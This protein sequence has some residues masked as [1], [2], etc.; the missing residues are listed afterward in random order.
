MD[1]TLINS[2]QGIVNAYRYAFSSLNKSF[3]EHKFSDAV[4]GAPLVSVFSDVFSLSAEDTARAVKYYRGYYAEKGKFEAEVY[5]EITN[6]L[7]SLKQSGIT[8]AVATLKNEGFARE[9]LEHFNISGYFDS[10]CGMDN[11]DTLTKSQLI[12]K[13]VS[14]CSAS[15][16]STV[17][18]GD[19]EY[20]RIGADKANVNFIAVTYG[21][22]FKNI[23]QNDVRFKVCSSPLCVANTILSEKKKV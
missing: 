18:V 16:Q 17:L 3:P 5:P 11:S 2:K 19:S 6:M 12:L 4:I 10:V 21:F 22:G 14:E 1:G 15:V 7:L 13:C 20:D 8:L 9:I 23:S